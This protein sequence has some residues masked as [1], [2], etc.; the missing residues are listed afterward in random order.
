MTNKNKS[1]SYT[2]L[3]KKIKEKKEELNMSYADLEARTG[4][5]K[6]TLQRYV[7]GTTSR[8]PIDFLF[9]LESAFNMA[10]GSLSGWTNE[11][12]PQNNSNSQFSSFGDLPVYR[13]YSE[14]MRTGENQSEQ[15]KRALSFRESSDKRL[16]SSLYPR[17]KAYT[18]NSVFAEKKEPLFT[19]FEYKNDVDFCIQMEDDSM[20]GARIMIGDI[21]FI[22]KCNEINNGE[23]AAIS[24]YGSITL[25]Y[26]YK[27]SSGI[28]LCSANNNS[29][30]TIITDPKE[31][32]FHILG[33][34]VYFQSK[35]PL[36]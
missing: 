34:A 6:S 14:Y 9:K 33:K 12:K 29:Y 32:D 16:Q 8:I 7:T 17:M 10:K 36:L 13:T 28:M 5:S 11:E 18:E 4:I 2:E 3:R 20:K 35:L 30:P 26:F 24:M 23:I 31:S 1:T 19:A 15:K 25:K 21:V 27:T 22:K